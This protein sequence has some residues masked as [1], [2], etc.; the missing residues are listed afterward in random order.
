MNKIHY[1]SITL[2][3]A[4][5]MIASQTAAGSSIAGL[6]DNMQIT[7]SPTPTPT[8]TPFPLTSNPSLL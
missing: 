3:G 4:I 1:I 5:I 2:L 8:L 6:D 7:P